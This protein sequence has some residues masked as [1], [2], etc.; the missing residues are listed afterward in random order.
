MFRGIKIY[1]RVVILIIVYQT[2]NLNACAQSPEKF[3]YQAL[4]RNAANVVLVN[5]AVGMRI[6]IFRG[7]ASGTLV[8]DETHTST[9]NAGGIV[10]LD[11]G[12]GT[13]GTGTF[14]SIDWS[15]GPYFIT[16]ET[17]PAGGTSY[18]ITGSQQ[19][20]SVPY[21]MYAKTANYNDLENKPILDGSETKVDAG[22]SI[23]VSGT[24]T[25]LTPYIINFSTQSLTSDQRIAIVSPYAGQIIWCNNCGSTGELQVY[26]GTTWTNWCGGAVTP[27]LPAITTTAASSIAA[28]SATSG[29]NVTSDGGGA[30]T[31]RGVCWS[32]SANPTTTD[33]KT[34]DGS[35]TGIFVSSVSGLNPLTTYYLRAYA[36]NST[37]TAYGNQESFT[38]IASIPTLTTTAVTPLTSTTASSG[39]N[40]SADGGASVTARGVC[41]STSPN[42]TISLATKTSNG[43]GTGIFAS[44]LD[45]L[46]SGTTYY[47]RAYATNSVGTAYG[48]EISFTMPVLP[49]VTTSSLSNIQSTSAICGGDV[50][51]DGGGA[52]TVKGVVWSNV[53]NPDISDPS[54]SKTN[55][56]TGTGSYPSSL[57]GLTLGTVYY[58]RAYATNTAGTA[59]GTERSFIALKI[60]DSF[61]GG[62]V[63]NIDATLLHGLIAS[64]ADQSAGIKWS[65]ASNVVT[66]ATGIIAGTGYTNT[67]TIVSVQGAGSYA[68]QLCWDYSVTVGMN[69]YADWY[70][71]SRDELNLLYWQRTVVGGFFTTPYYWSSSEQS[72]NNAISHNFNVPGFANQDKTLLRRVRAIQS[73]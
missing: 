22:T 40:I 16:T 8:Y 62:I 18:S 30:V 58:V 46:I 52:V 57:T 34:T 55:D 3:S 56:G 32:T 64:T 10:A 29:G 27:A 66:G 53:T 42:P 4:V 54:D 13:P 37:G 44:T 72:Q 28:Y 45:P 24:G 60:G 41:W 2:I 48:V 19:L 31:A 65:N 68:A 1:L 61:R 51:S 69:T 25:T 39:G 38:T 50:T 35:G 33:S 14:S 6:S 71:P 59:Y 36:T 63:Y 67:S 11:I 17:D 23:A 12:A 43:T 26:N 73:F 7:S 9:T 5:Q 47:V 15:N 70:L 21:A 20:T 49:I